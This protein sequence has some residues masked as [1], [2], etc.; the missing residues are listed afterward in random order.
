M[1]AHRRCKRGTYSP[2]STA[3]SAHVARH[4]SMRAVHA[5]TWPTWPRAAI[6]RVHRPAA[7]RSR[8]RLHP[9]PRAS[10]A[11]SC[12]TR[13]APAPPRTALPAPAVTARPT[14]PPALG[15]A[16]AASAPPLCRRRGSCHLRRPNVL[17]ACAREPSGSGL[18]GRVTHGTV[19]LCGRHGRDSGERCWP[20]QR[21]G[22]ASGLG[23]RGE[24]WMGSKGVCA[25]AFDD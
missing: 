19:G 21:V 12:V 23:Q 6:C 2:T 7:T 5:S 4:D 15:T 14:A 9:S 25:P 22:K 1:Q 18:V 10:A 20:I 11:A 24:S 17:Q 13:A 16:A 8:S 3:R